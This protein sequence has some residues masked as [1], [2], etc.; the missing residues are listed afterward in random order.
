MGLF[1]CGRGRLDFGSYGICAVM[2]VQLAGQ[3]FS[4]VCTA[5]AF[6]VDVTSQNFVLPIA[7]SDRKN[8]V[9]EKKAH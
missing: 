7:D 2:L 8:L 4:S 1:G 5:Q 9:F 6:I 3:C